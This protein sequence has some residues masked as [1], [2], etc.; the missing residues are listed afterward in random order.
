MRDIRT[1]FEQECD[2]H[3]PT[4]VGNFWKNNYIHNESNEDRK[5]TYQ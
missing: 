2:Y 3:K 1:L 5:K 4:R